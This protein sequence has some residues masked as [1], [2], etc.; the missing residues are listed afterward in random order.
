MRILRVLPAEQLP[1]SEA[2]SFK[3][4]TTTAADGLYRRSYFELPIKSVPDLLIHAVLPDLNV[5][6]QTVKMDRN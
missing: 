6:K 1:R 2:T 5:T 3:L 4:F